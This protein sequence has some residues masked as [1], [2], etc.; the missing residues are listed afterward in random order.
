MSARLDLVVVAAWFCAVGVA[1]GQTAPAAAE[2]DARAAIVANSANYD[3]FRY[4]KCR[5]RTTK[6]EALSVA[7][8]LAGNLQNVSSWDSRVAVDGDREACEG[9]APP[10]DPKKG[11]PIKD[12]GKM[13]YSPGD[14]SRYVS[15][16]PQQLRYLLPFQGASLTSIAK[17]PYYYNTTPLNLLSLGHRNVFGPAALLTQPERYVFTFVGAEEVLGRPVLT[18]RFD[19]RQIVRFP[20]GDT[21]FANTFSLDGSQGCI[22]VR[23]IGLRNGKIRS[24]IYVTEVAACKRGQWFP[25]RVVRIDTPTLAP[26]PFGVTELR[27]TELDAD[28]RPDARDLSVPLPAGTGIWE[29]DTPWHAFRLKQDEA[30]GPDDLPKLFAMLEK[31]DK[32][33]L[34][35]TAIPRTSPY[36]WLGWSIGIGVAL[37][38]CVGVAFWIR[39]GR[40]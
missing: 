32:Q 24:E 13:V 7:D 23:M 5:F 37:A 15:N 21:S 31:V 2:T 35:D 9:F 38:A 30:V 11:I 19:D 17:Q 10:P 1:R 34:M 22:P 12:G 33:P 40:K 3:S 26:T 29:R 20:E 36:R 28:H 8:A 16:G 25:L 27:V 18:V 14:S 39:R 6:G 4:Y